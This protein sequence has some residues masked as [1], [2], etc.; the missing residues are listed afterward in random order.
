MSDYRRDRRGFQQMP[1]ETRAGAVDVIVCEA[2]DRIAPDGED[3]AW[4]GKKLSTP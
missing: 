2:L 1:A 3:I 4:L